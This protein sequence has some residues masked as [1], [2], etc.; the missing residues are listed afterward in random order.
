MADDPYTPQSSIAAGDYIFR[1]TTLMY[2]KVP[3]KTLAPFLNVLKVTTAHLIKRFPVDY[4]GNTEFA[5]SM[6]SAQEQWADLLQAPMVSKYAYKSI[7]SDMREMKTRTSTKISFLDAQF[8]FEFE[9]LVRKHMTPSSRLDAAALQAF[10]KSIGWTY[11]F[12]GT[13]M[14]MPRGNMWARHPNFDRVK[15]RRLSK[16]VIDH[17]ELISPI[18]RFNAIES[19]I[20]KLQQLNAQFVHNKTTS[21]HVHF[22][23]KKIMDTATTRNGATV[24]A[25]ILY[26]WWYFE[27]FFVL[28]VDKNRFKDD[29]FNMTISNDIHDNT[30]VTYETELLEEES[31]D[32]ES[33]MSFD[34]RR[35][36]YFGGINIKKQYMDKFMTNMMKPT[37]SLFHVQA[38]FF[39]SSEY[40]S[41]ILK[42][43]TLNMTN[44][45]SPTSKRTLE[46]RLRH[47]SNDYAEI[48]QWIKLM[49]LFMTAAYNNAFVMSYFSRAQRVLLFDFNYDIMMAESYANVAALIAGQTTRAADVFHYLSKF[50]SDGNIAHKEVDDVL[51][52]WNDRWK[53]NFSEPVQKKKA[54]SGRKETFVKLGQKLQVY[55]GISAP[56]R[57][58]KPLR[59]RAP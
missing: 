47:G 6:E 56:I 8:G 15:V 27:A 3:P 53:K 20:F 7:D 14:A 17:T 55:G 58:N 12:D 10:A 41:T 59:S 34:S 40:S 57:K 23:H 48:V 18:M 42:Y 9:V 49:G 21:G 24:L 54:T 16:A 19:E 4:Q 45:D 35:N 5:K 25:K 32:A 51:A 38:Q 26:A 37:N 29:N 33:E 52:F 44:F 11:D 39:P 31:H 36:Q 50:I 28:L 13:V 22:S 2:S 43:Y 30:M 46:V 1:M